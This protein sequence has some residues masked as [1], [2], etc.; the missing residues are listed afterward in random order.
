MHQSPIECFYFTIIIVVFKIYKNK[1]VNY[2]FQDNKIF[3]EPT[4]KTNYYLDLSKYK[5]NSGD[6]IPEK[7]LSFVIVDFFNQKVNKNF[8]K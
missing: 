6:N 3:D 1:N 8:S 5:M 4:T 7:V 2:F